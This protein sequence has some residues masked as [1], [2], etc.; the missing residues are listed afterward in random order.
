MRSKYLNFYVPTILGYPII[1]HI[2]KDGIVDV[3]I[4]LD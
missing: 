4:T 1:L 2:P 3:L